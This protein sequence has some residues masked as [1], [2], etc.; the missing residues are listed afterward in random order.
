MFCVLGI[1]GAALVLLSHFVWGCSAE[2]S[3]PIRHPTDV[4]ALIRTARE[5]KTLLS[6]VEQVDKV[7][8]ERKIAM[9]GRIDSLPKDGMASLSQAITASAGRFRRPLAR[10][11][12]SVACLRPRA[13][14]SAKSPIRSCSNA[15]TRRPGEPCSTFDARQS[16]AIRQLS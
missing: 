10:R 15:D 2:T 6:L 12:R 1:Q 14:I 7:N 8:T 11:R 16:P 9:A 13:E 4:T 3:P 5:A